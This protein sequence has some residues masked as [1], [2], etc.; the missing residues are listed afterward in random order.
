MNFNNNQRRLYLVALGLLVVAIALACTWSLWG[1]RAARTSQSAPLPEITAAPTVPPAQIPATPA[2][3]AAAEE[4]A[5]RG[6][7]RTVV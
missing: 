4:T 3:S 6:S 2:A 7:V 1:Q 5:A